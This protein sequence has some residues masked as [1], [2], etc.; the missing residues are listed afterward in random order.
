M[1]RALVLF[2]HR[3]RRQPSYRELSE[4]VSVSAVHK[5]LVEIE[6][7]GWIRLGGGPRAIEIPIDV[8]DSIVSMEAL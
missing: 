8:Y 2:T 3:H 4:A 7:R 5:Y 6:N 1:L